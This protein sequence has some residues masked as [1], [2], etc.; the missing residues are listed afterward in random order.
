MQR[1]EG[2]KRKG[3]ACGHKRGKPAVQHSLNY[4]STSERVGAYEG[5]RD[6]KERKTRS[7]KREQK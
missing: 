5:K 3:E 7:G 4:S 6:K 2:K 1:R